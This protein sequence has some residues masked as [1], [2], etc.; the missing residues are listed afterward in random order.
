MA[1]SYDFVQLDVFTQTP[2]A[3]NP[4]AVFTWR[5]LEMTCLLWIP[6]PEQSTGPQGP[7]GP[8]GAIGPQ[9]LTGAAGAKKGDGR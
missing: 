6:L 9:G 4:L 5:C 1:A 7:A 3:S 8:V 2:L